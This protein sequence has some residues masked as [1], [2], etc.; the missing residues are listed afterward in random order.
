[1][2]TLAR[3]AWFLTLSLLLAI[4]LWYL[5]FL[6][7]PF[8]FWAEM[9]GATLLLGS[10]GVYKARSTLELRGLW[11]L[12]AW[13]LGIG[14]AL[15]LYLIFWLGK[16]LSQ[17]MLSTSS[18]EISAIYA[19]RGEGHPWVVL[20]VLLF[21]I[22]PG[23]EIFWRGYVQSSFSRLL[24][25]GRGYL[26]ASLLYGLTH[27]WAGNLMLLLAALTCGFYWG[28][29]YHKR[30]ELAPVIISHALWDALIFVVMPVQ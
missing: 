30:G 12:R 6:L 5:M 2:K 29:L 13:I 20:L 3:D 21:P 14:S 27:I 23:E 9:T 4:F 10:I 17:W 15:V 25:R 18:M 28:W 1:M 22:G 19:Y 11:T 16:I 26:V 24:G 7:K 8:N